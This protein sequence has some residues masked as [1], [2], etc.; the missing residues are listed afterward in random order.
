MTSL[1]EQ[2]N[3]CLALLSEKIPQTDII[4]TWLAPVEPESYDQERHMLTLRV[5]SEYVSSALEHFFVRHLSWALPQVFGKS[6]RLQY[7]LAP[8]EPQFA[9]VAA[10]LQQRSA[11]DTRRDPYHIRIP[12]A[13]KRLR[14]GLHYYLKGSE[15]WLPAYDKIASWLQDN[16]GRG[17]LCIGTPGLGKSLI[18]QRI[19]PVIL[20]NGG[21]PI[22]SVSAT[23]LHDR[24]PELLKERIV[25]IDDLGKEP[26]KHYGNTDQS[27][28]ELCNHAERTGQLLIITTNL[29]TT[30]VSPQYRHLYPL[31]I[32]ERYGRE[33]LDRLSVIVRAVLFDGES[34]R[35]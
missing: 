10:Y 33:V 30:V 3:R 4:N 13:E 8:K 27:F 26:A 5:P 14:D 11:Y 2:W 22:M 28:F 23:D 9:D 35:K 31:S 25:I 12:D 18:C 32:E 19:L 7:R 17:L 6:V 21:R 20:G 24:L 16:R 15:K 34:M 1:Q 29:S